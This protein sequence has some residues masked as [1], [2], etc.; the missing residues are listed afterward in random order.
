MSMF[1]YDP[2]P[3]L[4]ADIMARER[5]LCVRRMISPNNCEWVKRASRELAALRDEL[6]VVM[7]GR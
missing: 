5:A 2:V 3:I 7:K 6:L 4:V 1:K